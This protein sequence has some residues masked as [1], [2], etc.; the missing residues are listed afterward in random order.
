[1]LVMRKKLLLLSLFASM[2]GGGL[3]AQSGRIAKANI[4]MNGSSV[5]SVA[6]T[7]E[8]IV[9]D[10]VAFGYPVDDTLLIYTSSGWGYVGGHNDYGDMS[11][12]ERV[13]N[14]QGYTEVYGARF[15]FGAA[16]A[17]DSNSK[18]IA[19][20]WP[21]VS[22]QP[23]APINSLD[24]RIQDIIAQQGEI[25][26]RFPSPV[27]VSGPFYVGF[28]I[29]YVTGDTVGLLSNEDG[30]TIPGTAWEQW[31]DSSWHPYSEVGTG[32]GVNLT[33]TIYPLV[34]SGVFPVTITPSSSVVPSGTPVQLT[35]TG[36][37]TYTWYPATGL[38]CNNCPNPTATVTDTTTYTAV[39]TLT[40]FNCVS[41]AYATIY[42]TVVVSIDDNLFEGAVSVFPNPNA[43]RF[44]VVFNQ[45][46]ATDLE[47]GLY[48]QL[49][50]RVYF[51]SLTDFAGEYNKT[52]DWTDVAK[53]LY[54]LRISDAQNNQFVSKLIVE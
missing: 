1:M 12:A 8:G 25:E 16:T 53:G 3:I 49:G 38:S 29:T 31:S 27:S 46:V 7:P 10:T 37:T 23:G 54:T 22:G 19:H 36:G 2:I 5:G 33:T 41:S 32:W 26:V 13:V 52:F 20:I 34:Y 50:Q 28:S 30:K 39:A 9:C 14:V 4:G 18:I 35:A 45:A 6:E 11:K 48:N 40:G 47:I 17:A 21:E 24:I 15:S 51:E 42:T 43:G 44:A